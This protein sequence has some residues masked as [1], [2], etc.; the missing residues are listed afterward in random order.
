MLAAVA[1]PE[2]AGVEERQWREQ[3][4]GA[5][6]SR[7]RVLVQLHMAKVQQGDNPMGKQQF[8]VHVLSGGRQR[9]VN[10]AQGS[11]Q[12]SRSRY[13][14]YRVA[15]AR[16][17][18]SAV[19]GPSWAALTRS[20]GCTRTSVP[21]RAFGGCKRGTDQGRRGMEPLA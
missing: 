7:K 4:A 16:V 17:A 6:H 21:A 1:T 19:H 8:A 2:E 10:T 12:G 3:A 5:E 14:Q 9:H 13:V 11:S 20:A 18:S 15:T